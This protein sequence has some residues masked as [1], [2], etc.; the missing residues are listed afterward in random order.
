MSDIPYSKGLAGAATVLREVASRSAGCVTRRDGKEAFP[1]R[2]AAK[3]NEASR[4]PYV[5]LRA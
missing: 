2:E 4:T 5:T 1:G 3:I